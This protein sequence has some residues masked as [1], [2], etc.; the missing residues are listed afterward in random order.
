MS[1]AANRREPSKYRL[2]I[3]GRFKARLEGNEDH[4]TAT[5]LAGP[6]WEHMSVC[7]T[8]TMTER[9]WST[10]CEGLSRGLRDDVEVEE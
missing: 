1:V 7:G 2:R 4:V 10:L 6:D 8:L 3:L 5:V 9:E